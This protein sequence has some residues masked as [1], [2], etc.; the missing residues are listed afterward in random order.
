[1]Y[2]KK[3]NVFNNHTALTKTKRSKT[4]TK[5]FH[6]PSKFSHHFKNLSRLKH[7]K[8]FLIVRM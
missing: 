4:T 2:M 3:R 8:R 1:M 7:F 5:Q 6:Q